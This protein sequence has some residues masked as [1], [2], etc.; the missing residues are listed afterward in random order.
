[1]EKRRKK[2]KPQKSNKKKIILLSILALL[3]FIIGFAGVYAW[4][5]LGSMKTAEINKDNESVGINQETA[6][7]LDKQNDILNIAFFGV[8]QRDKN[9]NGRSDSTMVLSIDKKHNK[10]KMTSIMRDSYVNI[11]GHG[12]DKLNHAYSFGGPQ[13]AIKTLNQ[14]YGLNIRDFVAV[15]FGDLA[16]IIDEL[17]G[18][19]ID[20]KSNEVSL[21]NEYINDVASVTGLKGTPLRGAGT[22]TLSGVQ[23]VAY[24]RIRYV[25]NGDFERTE[26]QRTV[27]TALFNKIK[28]AGPSEYPSLVNK[29]MPY[30]Q[31]SMNPLDIIKIGTSAL[32]NGIT[33]LEQERFP[34][35]GYCNGAT[36][37]GVWYLQ[38]DEQATKDQI[39]KYIYED[40]KPTSGTP[41]F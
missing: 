9:E 1:M 12:K 25:G 16:K 28:A 19:Q 33:N 15:N 13:L 17:G 37:N 41:K 10:I 29:L 36:I 40:I 7:K 3:I 27:L 21:V 30:V 38:F 18:V 31:T 39:Y 24:S 14:N 22:Q 23:A 32:T 4:R 8:D 26:R 6:D 35:D 20:I 11:E 5:V 34:V 2:Q